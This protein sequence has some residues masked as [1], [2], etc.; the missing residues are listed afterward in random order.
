MLLAIFG[1]FL[2]KF[3]AV[4]EKVAGRTMSWAAGHTPDSPDIFLIS[5][6]YFTTILDVGEASKSFNVNIPKFFN[7]H[8]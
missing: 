7:F 1:R 8:F 5:K 4:F 6:E 2:P 3:L